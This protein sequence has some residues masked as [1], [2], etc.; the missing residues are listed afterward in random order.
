MRRRKTYLDAFGPVMA[1][2]FLLILWLVVCTVQAQQRRGA[3]Y[4]LEASLPK[5]RITEEVLLEME[6]LPG[7]CGRSVCYGA[8][9]EITIGMYTGQAEILGVD[10]DAGILTPVLSAGEKPAGSRPLLIVGED[11]FQSLKDA[12]GHAATQRQQEILKQQL[13]ELEAQIAVEGAEGKSIADTAQFLGMAKESGVYMDASLMRAWLDKWNLSCRI[14]RVSLVIRGLANAE[15]AQESLYKAGFEA[16]LTGQT[17]A[18]GE[19][20]L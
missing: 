18:T 9:A 4:T 8:D 12:Y 2:V 16:E 14:R 6:K 19:R 3:L 1:G 10:L 11:F 13:G 15:S 5:G 17:G 7:F 20:F